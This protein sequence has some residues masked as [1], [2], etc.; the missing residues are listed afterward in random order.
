MI[1]HEDLNESRADTA[2]DSHFLQTQVMG[3]ELPN[4]ASAV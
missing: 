1:F 2:K 4:D 3:I